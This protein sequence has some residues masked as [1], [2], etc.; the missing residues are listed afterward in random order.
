MES[1]I[2]ES[3]EGGPEQYESWQHE[4]SQYTSRDSHEAEEHYQ[5][6]DEL[7]ENLEARVQKYSKEHKSNGK[8]KKSERKNNISYKGK[9]EA[10]EINDGEIVI[11]YH[12]YPDGRIEALFE[13]KPKG[14]KA[15]GK[16]AP[17]GGEKER[18]D[19]GPKS[20]A[21]REI[22]E[23]FAHKDAIEV[24]LNTLEDDGELYY[25]IAGYDANGKQ[26][27]VY[28][29]SAKVKSDKDWEKVK[30]SPL[31]PATST[32][33]T[34]YARIL[35]LETIL[36]KSNDNYAYNYGA[37]IKQFFKERHPTQ[38]R[39]ALYCDYPLPKMSTNHG[40]LQ[41]IDYVA[42]KSQLPSLN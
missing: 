7:N 14:S 27:K 37:I 4:D 8:A 13:E 3:P 25:T 33:L 29:R 39:L 1:D 38:Y 6:F 26:F 12:E 31:T 40:H 41:T 34:G 35:P 17:L 10:Y 2:S 5:E 21:K 20:T 15:E 22:I 28:I 24:L 11:I 32:D 19:T 23:E 30:K 9:E 16:L 36:S 42:N 18:Y